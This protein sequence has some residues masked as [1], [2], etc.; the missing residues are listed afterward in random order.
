MESATT[1]KRPL[2]EATVERE[3]SFNFSSPVMK[4]NKAL[5]DLPNVQYLGD[6]SI[7]DLYEMQQVGRG[8]FGIVYKGISRTDGEIVAIKEMQ[9]DVEKDA[10]MQQ[11]KRELVILKDASEHC[12]G[13]VNTLYDVLFDS[14]EDKLYL[15][16]EFLQGQEMYQL[17]HRRPQRFSDESYVELA[18]QLIAGFQCL[19]K[20][21]IA[22]RDVKLENMMLANYS[23]PVIIDFGLSCIRRCNPGAT[24]T[25]STIAPEIML[26][27]VDTEEVKNWIRADI[28]SLGC[29][30][31][32]MVMAQEYPLQALFADSFLSRNPKQIK[33]LEMAYLLPEEFPTL[34]LENTFPRDKFPQMYERLKR[35]LVNNPKRRS[36]V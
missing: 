36:L 21:G 31:Y 2:P 28:W 5:L 30:L 9:L 20:A 1:K 22:H 17:F 7:Q 33:R 3:A 19:H 4:R 35:M 10:L 16:L 11:M 18:D 14:K 6:E 13:Y 26:N 29:S 34:L 27:A 32:E 23:H 15:I 8:T 12:D 25:P 24:G